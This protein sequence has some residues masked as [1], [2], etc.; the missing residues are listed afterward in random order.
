MSHQRGSVL[1]SVAWCAPQSCSLTPEELDTTAGRTSGPR[2]SAL[3]TRRLRSTHRRQPAKFW[4]GPAHRDD[5]TAGSCGGS[6]EHNLGRRAAWRTPEPVHCRAVHT[7]SAHAPREH[8][9]PAVGW[10]SPD[11]KLRVQQLQCGCPRREQSPLSTT[12][13]SVP[14]YL[15]GGRGRIPLS[16]DGGTGAQG[17]RCWTGMRAGAGGYRGRVK[18]RS[19]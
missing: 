2:R 11:N 7:R 5:P 6:P 19:F 12:Q 8:T 9:M 1:S 18:R 13:P 16:T 10:T 3:P 14:F 4:G 15:Q 17:V